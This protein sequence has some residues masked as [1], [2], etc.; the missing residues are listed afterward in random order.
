MTLCYDL[1]WMMEVCKTVL[2]NSSTRYYRSQRCR[3]GNNCEME[4]PT[5]TN[6]DGS[7]VKKVDIQAATSST[8]EECERK[9]TQT[10]GKKT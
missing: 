7:C 8:N 2:P 6:A 3:L 9:D 10:A 1:Y 5:T 4:T